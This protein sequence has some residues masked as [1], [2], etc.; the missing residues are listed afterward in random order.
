MQRVQ[1]PGNGRRIDRSIGGALTATG[2][3][4][5][6]LSTVSALTVTVTAS[7]ASAP[8]SLPATTQPRI[9]IFSALPREK[10]K[11]KEA[12]LTR[13]SRWSLARHSLDNTR[14]ATYSQ[15]GDLLLSLSHPRSAGYLALTNGG[16]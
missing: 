11:N 3:A 16:T 4:G 14:Y 2:E 9:S 8:R 10:Y 6:Y 15:R 1:A 13:H 5:A 7:P 12:P